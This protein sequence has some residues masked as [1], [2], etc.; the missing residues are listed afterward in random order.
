MSSSTADS[1]VDTVDLRYFLLVDRFDLLVDLLG[2]PICVPRPV[3]D[4][5]EGDVPEEVMSEVPRSILVQTRNSQE[6]SRLPVERALSLQNANRLANVHQVHADGHLDVI[7]MT[8]AERSLFG[9]LLD[10]EHAG[11]FGLK[12]ALQV[13]EAGCVAIAAERDLL[14][15]T[16]DGNALT[17]LKRLKPEARSTRIRALLQEAMNQGLLSRDDANATHAEMCRLGFWDKTPPF[18]P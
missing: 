13:G 17:A 4:P 1:I 9:R 5:D 10:R 11:E 14:V 7:D 16:D 15:A 12:V 2:R 6:A 18:E 3:F 8:V